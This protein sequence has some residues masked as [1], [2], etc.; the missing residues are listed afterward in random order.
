M[1]IEPSTLGSSPWRQ[2]RGA[3]I[4]CIAFSLTVELLSIDRVGDLSLLQPRPLTVAVVDAP[5]ADVLLGRTIELDLPELGAQ[6]P[7]TVRAIQPCPEVE[8]ANHAGRRLITGTF[9][10]SAGNVLKLEI[11]KATSPIGVTPNH[12]FWSADRHAFVEAGQLL[13]GEQL[14]Q[15]D[16]TLVQVTRITPH[17]G[18]PVEVYN[19]EVDAEHVYHVGAG[20]VL[21]HNTY[22]TSLTHYTSSN[23]LGEIL[24]SARLFAS[25]GVKNARYGPGQYFTDLVPGDLTKWQIARRLFGTP[26]VGR[27]M[28]AFLQVDVSDLPI[29]QVA[30]HIF[31]LEGENSLD[32]LGRILNSG[33]TP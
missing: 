2:L 13:V 18:P 11:E 20:G 8:T 16:G 28:E 22:P 23:R 31:L 25:K 15:A 4:L 29:M 30:P 24:E 1:S 19:L 21:V 7:A 32:L 17:T 3:A 26:K 27:K 12:P 14:Q 5:L 10:H 9:H 33:L 6:G